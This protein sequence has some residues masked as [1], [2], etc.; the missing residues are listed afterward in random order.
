MRSY[1]IP[2]ITI[3]FTVLKIFGSGF[4]IHENAASGLGHAFS[5]SAVYAE[6]AS[7]IAVNPAL[8]SRQK[9]K[10]VSSSLIMAQPY[11]DTNIESSTLNSD[12]SFDLGFGK[13]SSSE[14]I[15]IT[16][17][18]GSSSGSAM[19]PSLYYIHPLNKK[20]GIGGGM[21]TNFALKGSQEDG[22]RARF[23]QESS[24]LVTT[25]L[26]LSASYRLNNRWAFGLGL[27][28][29][30]AEGRFTKGIPDVLAA[31]G[32]L[33]APVILFLFPDS[34]T[35]SSGANVDGGRAIVTGK[36]S[37]FNFNLGVHFKLDKRNY[38][39]FSYH[40]SASIDLRGK[41][42]FENCSATNKLVLASLTE[43]CGPNFGSSFIINLPSFWQMGYLRKINKKLKIFSSLSQTKWS[44]F[45]SIDITNLSDGSLF[46]KVELKFVDTIRMGI[47]STYR[48]N[49]QFRLRGGIA[50]DQA[51]FASGETSISATD[52]DRTIIATG[53]RWFAGK[54]WNIDFGYSHYFFKRYN[55]DDKVALKDF[56][57]ATVANVSSSASVKMNGIRDADFF[58]T[59]LNWKF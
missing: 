37:G 54:K 34:D 6:D 30:N 21:F 10:Q 33:F 31:S 48:L 45:G 42:E 44:Q 58:A 46:Q 2:I 39:G 15:A 49:K 25:N 16:G 40:S 1:T 53:L 17:H 52:G 29:I 9:K 24:E 38:F 4:Q 11:S 7:L 28:Y 8:M 41:T 51:P 26:N 22:Y 14:K 3:L 50:L 5:G 23:A 59:Q 47:G 43:I 36:G 27:N 32:S 57:L 13:T 20:W 55:V 35:S 56:S 12:V 19:I 18:S